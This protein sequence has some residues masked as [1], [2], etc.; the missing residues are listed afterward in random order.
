MS[1]SDSLVFT[2]TNDMLGN[3]LF[4]ILLIQETQ[5]ERQRDIQAEGEAGSLW[6]THC[7]PQSQ[8]PRITPRATGR[9]RRSTAEPR[10]CP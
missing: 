4:K 6:G 8:D 10:R 9:C 5:K 2:N 1:N 7:R 3:Y